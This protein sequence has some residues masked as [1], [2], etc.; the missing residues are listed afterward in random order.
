MLKFPHFV[1]AGNITDDEFVTRNVDTR[2]FQYFFAIINC[3]NYSL[4]LGF[5]AHSAR[6][7]RAPVF[8]SPFPRGIGRCAPFPPSIADSFFSLCYNSLAFYNW[9]A[10]KSIISIIHF[11]NSSTKIVSQLVGFEP[12]LPEGI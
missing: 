7:L 5:G 6:A 11:L 1:V 4:L 8:L 3:T 10:A 2:K 9:F 12:T